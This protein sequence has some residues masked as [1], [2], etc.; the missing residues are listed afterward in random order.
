MWCKVKVLFEAFVCSA[1]NQTQNFP[2]T[3]PDS[4]TKLFPQP[5]FLGNSKKC[6]GSFL[7]GGQI[8]IDVSED[9]T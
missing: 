3:K 8:K 7:P 1:V 4:P 5:M 2:H 9:T 6:F